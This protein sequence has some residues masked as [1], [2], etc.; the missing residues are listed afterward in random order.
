VDILVGNIES[1]L[2]G[3]ARSDARCELNAHLFRGPTAAASGLSSDRALV[4][5]PGDRSFLT[6]S[7]SRVETDL[8]KEGVRYRICGHLPPDSAQANQLDARGPDAPRLPT[9]VVERALRRGT[10]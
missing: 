1:R 2:S 7:L 4:F 8:R 3:P 6:G 9:E 10:G 5:E